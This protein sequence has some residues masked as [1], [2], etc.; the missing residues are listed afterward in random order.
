M[1]CKYRIVNPL[2]YDIYMN[3]PVYIH[4]SAS[5]LPGPPIDFDHIEQAL[6]TFDQAPLRIRKWIERTTPVMK[7]ILDIKR[8]HYAFDPETGEYFDDNI[9]MAVKSAKAACETAGIHAA[10]IDLLCYG[11]PHQDQMPTATVRIQ[12]QLGIPCCQEFSIHANCTSAYK[13]LYL[14]QKL[15]ACGESDYAL[16]ISANTASSELRAEYY[17]QK[18]IDKESLFLRWFLCDGAGAVLLSS[19]K[20]RGFNFRLEQTF[21]E[22]VGYNKPSLMFN[23]RP[24]YWINPRLE[25]EKGLH[26]LKQRFRNELSTPVFQEQH[27]SVFFNGLKRM[28]AKTSIPVSS[29]SHFQVNLPSHHIAE[30]VMEECAQL[31]IDP[32]SFYTRLSDLGYSGPPAAFICLDKIIREE[33]FSPGN[34]IVSFVTEVSKFMQAGYSIVYENDS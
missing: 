1:T 28:L 16:V 19:H 6:G 22:S 26:H 5:Y 23:E 29:I 9:S 25:Y 4:G 12:E 21:T 31:G 34:R 2:I 15:I 27:G 18:L 14:A 32:N 17:N 33:S 11:S 7:E 10:D 13:A 20:K 24:A 3:R 30:S 8:V